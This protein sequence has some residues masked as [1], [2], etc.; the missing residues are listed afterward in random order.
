MLNNI[1][2]SFVLVAVVA[3]LSTGCKYSKQYQ[4]IT[5]TGNQYTAAIDELLDK[6]SEL[7]IDSTS[8]KLLQNDSFSNINVDFYN[9]YKSNDK[10]M[11]EIISRIRQHNSLLG[12]YFNTLNQLAVSKAPDNLQTEI[13][14]IATNLQTIGSQLQTSPLLPR[15]MVIGEIGKLVVNSKIDGVLKNELEQ[16]H[17]IIL[18]QLKIQEEMLTILSELM[19]T[20]V[21]SIKEARE[22]R[23]VINPIVGSEPI[24]SPKQWMDLRKEILLMDKQVQEIE[25]AS[26]A[27]YD[28]QNIYKAAVEG[29][30]NSQYL[31][32]TLEDIDRFLA[33]LQDNQQPTQNES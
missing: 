15:P 10:E 18:K 14:G 23:L 5:K 1:R 33:L 22:R 20:R 12:E 32:S 8:E 30:V 24:S 6:A 28:F 3:T 19:K 13:T 29:K 25:K 16:R 21:E 26:G 27:L 11:L 7:Q 31:N 9:N 2:K 17:P 4:E